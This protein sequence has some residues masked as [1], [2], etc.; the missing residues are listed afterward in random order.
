M[1]FENNDYDPPC[2]V[3]IRQIR[4]L[5]SSKSSPH[6]VAVDGGS[7]AGK[8][9]L[10]LLLA[11][12]LN[13]VSIPLDDFYAAQIPDHQWDQFSVE[14]RFQRSFEWDRLRE[15]VIEPLLAG[16]PARWYAFDFITGLRA[17]GTYGMESEPKMRD[18]AVVILLDGA[19][20]ASPPLSDLVNF[21]I[22]VD[23]PIAERHVRVAAR[24]E[25]EFLKRWHLLWDPVEDY[26][27]NHLRPRESFDLVV[28]NRKLL[29]KMD[30][31]F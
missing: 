12:E 8:S 31:L 1:S 23:V 27:F 7:G 6:V 18:P 25:E 26:Y 15:I 29:N 30:D 9:T 20:S 4:L 10:V 5:K 28:K 13:A 24:E 19:F 16:Q 3:I 22:L 17:D 2:T 21:T 11:K 14:E